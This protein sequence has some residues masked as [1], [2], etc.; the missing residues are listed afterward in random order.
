MKRVARD[1]T[2]FLVVRL[3]NEGFDRMHPGESIR[4][5]MVY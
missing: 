3:I 2:K 1:E 4:P 5:L